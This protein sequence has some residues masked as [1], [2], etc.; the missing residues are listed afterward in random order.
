MKTYISFELVA[1]VMLLVTILFYSYKNWISVAKNRIFLVLLYIASIA[2]SADLFLELCIYFS[3][4]KITHHLVVISK[5]WGSISFVL[6]YYYLLQ[7][8][9]AMTGLMYI[10]KKIPFRFLQFFV[11]VGVL[12]AVVPLILGAFLLPHAQME[13]F[14]LLASWAQSG[15]MIFCILLGTVFVCRYRQKLRGREYLILLFSNALL[16]G[17]VI[18]QVVV[19]TRSLGFY[20]IVSFVLVIYYMLLH[21][22][23]R[24][25]F[26]SSGC[27]ARAGFNTVLMEKELY[28]ENFR[29]LGLCINN[30]E[31]I[32]N[33]CSEE[34]IA[35]LH[36]IIGDF[37]KKHCGRHHVYH[38]HS[39]EYVL[40]YKV[41]TNIEKKHQELAAILPNYVRIHEKNISLLC[42]F[43]TLEFA[44]ADYQMG[45]FH[46]IITSMRKIARTQMDRFMLLH[47]K[48]ESQDDITKDLEAMRIV[49]A[50]ISS[51]NFSMSISPIQSRINSEEY[52]YEFVVHEHLKDG[53]EIHQEKIWSLAMEMGSIQDLGKIIVELVCKYIMLKRLQDTPVKRVHLNLSSSQVDGER[54]AGEYVDCLKRYKI[55]GDYIC[56]EITLMQNADYKKM[57]EAF[58]VLREYGI[59]LL[60]DQFG[61]TVCN[62]KTV[63][64]MPFDAVKI[65]HHMVKVFCSGVSNQ[66]SYM[67]DMLN[68]SGWRIIL[69]GVDEED[70]FH[71]LREMECSDFQGMLFEKDY[72]TKY[73]SAP[74]N[75]IG[76]VAVD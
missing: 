73:S 27:F 7:Y 56:M 15:I 26:L 19:Q 57:E 9:M 34:E 2:L 70:Q 5:V 37:L 49:N 18:Y 40:I 6:L 10:K 46:S 55:P 62:L 53:E 66:L 30:I 54:I 72:S 21:N 4:E 33:Y 38:I 47:Y 12:A 1:L 24:Y 59:N 52:S 60:L 23:D 64:N 31:S 68:S 42:D 74:C 41:N 28:R 45:N 25:R 63:L 65:N 39:F 75:G 44:E 48:G 36:R 20:Y 14:A 71:Q 29:C 69:D 58:A 35:M 13:H 3:G 76:G 61:V 8:D 32:T 51:K 50:C 17:D 16:M 43:Y 67:L 11:I 22:V